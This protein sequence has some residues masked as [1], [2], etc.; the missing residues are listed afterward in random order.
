MSRGGQNIPNVSK[1]ITHM[2]KPTNVDYRHSWF[3]IILQIDFIESPTHREQTHI[4]IYT[5]IYWK[6]MYTYIYAH[7]YLDVMFN[8]L[9]LF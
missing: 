9:F 7:K 3:L 2:L 1:I 4:Y 8:Y 5:Q 6:A